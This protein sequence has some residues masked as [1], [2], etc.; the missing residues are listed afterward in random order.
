MESDAGPQLTGRLALIFILI[1]LNAFFAASEIA[2]I[3]VDKK[4]LSSQA[5]EGNK[6][7]KILL[8][9][10]KEPSRFLST[11]QVGITFAGFSHR[12]Q[13]LLDFPMTLGNY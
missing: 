3:S 12:H 7:A 9:L 6:K 10:L 13:L 1:L 11:I 8:D 5:E 4:K 2:I